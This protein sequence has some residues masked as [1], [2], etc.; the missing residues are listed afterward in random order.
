LGYWDS[1]VSV[2]YQWLRNGSAVA[3]ANS[4]TYKLSETDRGKQI[5][6][7]VTVSKYGYSAVTKV[8]SPVSFG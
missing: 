8:T 3:N 2:S 5:S 4:K 6:L 7:Q 1:G